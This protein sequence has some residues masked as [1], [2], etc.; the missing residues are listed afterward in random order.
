MFC[1]FSLPTG[2]SSKLQVL[3]L[4]DSDLQYCLVR[5]GDNGRLPALLLLDMVKTTLMPASG[6]PTGDG[7][8]GLQDEDLEMQWRQEHCGGGMSGHRRTRKA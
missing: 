5:Y 2:T 7:R 6:V 3:V 4:S 1:R 8:R